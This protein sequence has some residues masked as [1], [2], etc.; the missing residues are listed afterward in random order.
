MKDLWDLITEDESGMRR[1]GDD[2][3]KDNY[4][5]KT[6]DSEKLLIHR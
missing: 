6:R 3:D 2:R 5:T 4:N 1:K